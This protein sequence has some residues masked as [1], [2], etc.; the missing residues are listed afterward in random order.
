MFLLLKNLTNHGNRLI[1]IDLL[2]LEKY[3]NSH[4]CLIKNF[5]NY[6]LIMVIVYILVEI[7]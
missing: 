5:D 1:E 6:L 7:V 3:G 2:Y 4:Y